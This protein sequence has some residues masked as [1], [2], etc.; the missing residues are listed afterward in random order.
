MTAASTADD[1][2]STR[3]ATPP[4]RSLRWLV[5]LWIAIALVRL[6]L[7]DR[8]FAGNE[9]GTASGIPMVVARNMARY[10]LGVSGGLGAPINHGVVPPEH[11][12]VYAHHPP[13]LPASTA[14]LFGV[15]GEN[16]WV[17]RL[18][19]MLCTLAT[20]ALLGIVLSRRF[21]PLAGAAAMLFYA[22]APITLAFGDMNDYVGS[23]LVL[24]GVATVACWSR[25]V[26]TPRR[27]WLAA[28]VACF[29]VG[30][31]IDWPIF[32]LVPLLAADHVRA[33]GRRRWLTPLA[34]V[35]LS[36][37]LLAALGAW[38]QRSTPGLSFAEK[39][40]DRIWGGH[41]QTGLGIP[42]GAW[43]VR[44]VGERQ[45]LLQGLAPLPLAIGY[46][47]LRGRRWPAGDVPLLL[48]GWGVLHL[49]VGYQA[50]YQHAFWSV[51]VTPGL[52]AGGAVMAA[53]L[54]ADRDR[55]RAALIAAAIA[56]SVVVSS[57]FATRLVMAEYPWVA[58]NG[59][60]QK[61]L[62]LF[63]RS[64]AGEDEGVLTSDRSWESPLWWYADRQLRPTVS[65]PAELDRWLRPGIY[66]LPFNY[67]QPDGP[68]PT[69]FVLPA[70]HRRT[71]PA[72]TA[73]LDRRFET[74][75]SDD[76]FTVYRLR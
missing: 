51:V 1:V 66:L 58:E 11:F 18:V 24:A 43:L 59:Y 53:R 67:T 61:E 12:V 64:V 30:A 62:G 60:S 35:V 54:L 16:E 46:L 17:A 65:T 45:W 13:L 6:S 34:M 28:T 38:A 72:L 29:L 56:S 23:P 57:I 41:D 47:A 63:I 70:S 19:P 68:A 21:G 26:Q 44:V 4:R 3:P 74:T 15:L 5:P 75:H 27:R 73:E 55:L 69:W 52:A 33:F 36:A 9:E 32:Y 2:L 25:Y 49:L 20:A 8:P 22:L 42:I 7:V 76:R 31:F 14:I 50:N 39:V 48:L 40:A 37:V 71:M 10:G